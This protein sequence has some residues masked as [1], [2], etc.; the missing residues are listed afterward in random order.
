[1]N[2][3]NAIYLLL[4]SFNIF[5]NSNLFSQEG[6]ITNGKGGCKSFTG[7]TTNR[8]N[9]WTGSC[10]SGYANGYGT[11]IV[12]ENGSLYYTYIGNLVSGKF[13]G[14]CTLSWATGD[15][16]EG[17]HTNHVVGNGN[18]FFAD[19]SWNSSSQLTNNFML[20]GLGEHWNA[21]IK[22]KFVGTFADQKFIDGTIYDEKGNVYGEVK[23][24]TVTL[25]QVV[26]TP[27]QKQR[28]IIVAKFKT[29]LLYRIGQGWS[30][31]NVVGLYLNNEL[32]GY[33]YYSN[34][35]RE[36]LDFKWYPLYLTENARR[37]LI[38]D[39]HGYEKA[40]D[41]SNPKFLAICNTFSESSGYVTGGLHEPNEHLGLTV[42]SVFE[43]L[44]TKFKDKCYISID[45]GGVGGHKSR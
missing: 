39:G 18:Y 7:K 2:M 33:M 36:K 26:N 19:G 3:K 41:W 25:K 43:G 16:Y 8:T 4:F 11:L 28:A 29:R 12:Y 35:T 27:V 45:I 30:D 20:N 14:K 23:N 13:N 42:L 6:Y 10:Q 34:D 5:F 17:Y 44:N 37:K 21:S 15:R 31:I 38:D 1:M 24:G 22:K 9:S 32:L 40:F